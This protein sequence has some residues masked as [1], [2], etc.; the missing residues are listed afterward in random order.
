M[1]IYNMFNYISTYIYLFY[2]YIFIFSKNLYNFLFDKDYKY[3][4]MDKETSFI[5]EFTK[6]EIVSDSSSPISPSSLPF[7]CDAFNEISNTNFQD[8]SYQDISYQDISYQDLSI[9]EE[10]LDGLVDTIITN[11]QDNKYISK[12]DTKYTNDNTK[13]YDEWEVI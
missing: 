9:I 4:P 11:T 7:F 3:N 5:N 8:I 10:I 13:F 12:Y 6:Y 2:N 1:F